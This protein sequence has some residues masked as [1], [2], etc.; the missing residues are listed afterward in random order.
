MSAP[1]LAALQAIGYDA[2]A[3][4]PAPASILLFASGLFGIAAAGRRRRESTGKR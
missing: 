3:P 1:E 4:V 2:V